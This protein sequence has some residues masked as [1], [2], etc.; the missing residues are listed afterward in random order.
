MAVQP[1]S[2]TRSITQCFRYS[3]LAFQLCWRWSHWYRDLSMQ[4][5]CWVSWLTEMMSS[6]CADLTQLFKSCRNMLRWKS[7]WQSAAI[8]RRTATSHLLDDFMRIFTVR[9]FEIEE[10]QPPGTDH[11]SWHFSLH[12]QHTERSQHLHNVLSVRQPWKLDHELWQCDAKSAT[13]AFHT[14]AVC[15]TLDRRADIVVGHRTE[16]NPLM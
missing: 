5:S 6:V 2:M 13:L 4:M 10:P 14:A 9:I 7:K 1:S 12:L 15:W 11:R 3:A 8:S 16:N